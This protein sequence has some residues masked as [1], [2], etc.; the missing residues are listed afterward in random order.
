MH[1][2]G[3]LGRWP[4]GN[5]SH[6]TTGLGC[7][8]SAC[9]AGGRVPVA[10]RHPA[11]A[12]RAEGRAARHAAGA[13]SGGRRGAGPRSRLRRRRPG[14]AAGAGAHLVL[15][16]LGTAGLQRAGPRP[17]PGERPLPAIGRPADLHLHHPQGHPLRTAVRRHRPAAGLHLRRR[18]PVRPAPAGA[19]AEPLRQ[20]HQGVR[21]VRRG[22]GQ[23]DLRHA[24]GR[25]RRPQ[26]HPAGARQ[27]LPQH[28]DA[29]LLLSGAGAVRLRPP[30]RRGLR[31]PPDRLGTLRARQVLAGRAHRTSGPAKR[32][33]RRRSSRATST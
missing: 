4:G 18:A 6:A 30:S 14:A 11:V 27:R 10:D 12:G 19:L 2:T 16:R 25:R 33:S 7:A 15:V 26:D 5:G 20:P 23:D 24:G 31:H 3:S 13:R 17:R 32:P 28:P 21:R 9:A 1:A 22:Q 29:A 8:A